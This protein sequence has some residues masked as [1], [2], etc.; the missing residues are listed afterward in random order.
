[1]VIIQSIVLKY[2][3]CRIEIE[4]KSIFFWCIFKGKV[5]RLMKYVRENEKYIRFLFP[6]FLSISCKTFAYISMTQL[7][8]IYTPNLWLL[9]R[10][11]ISTICQLCWNNNPTIYQIYVNYMPHMTQKL[12]NYDVTMTQLYINYIQTMSQIYT[13]YNPTI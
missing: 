13:N 1:M 12:H 11:Y 6:L 7:F 10:N 8:T 4:I 9:W 2:W 5:C 3:N